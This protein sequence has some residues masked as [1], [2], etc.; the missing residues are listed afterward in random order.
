MLSSFLPNTTS[1]G[2]RDRAGENISALRRA[3]GKREARIDTRESRERRACRATTGP[4]G[5]LM[6]ST[7]KRRC[8]CHRH[9]R[10]GDNW[11]TAHRAASQV[12]PGPHQAPAKD[13]MSPPHCVQHVGPRG[14]ASRNTARA[15][16]WVRTGARW[17]RVLSQAQRKVNVV[18]TRR[19]A[20]WFAGHRRRL[21][22]ARPGS[23]RRMRM[24]R[25]DNRSD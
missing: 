12:K 24:R 16:P 7:G 9:D 22:P 21:S 4:D 17:M 8:R 25:L 15:T 19:V 3:R 1:A 2:M 10:S 14:A 23:R 13:N 6:I 11:P 5:R 18:L 20:A